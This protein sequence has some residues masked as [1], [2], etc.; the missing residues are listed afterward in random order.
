[1]LDQLPVLIFLGLLLTACLSDISTMKIP[2]WISIV[3]ATDY[4]VF[5]IILGQPLASVGLHILIGF[6]VL[7]F[8]FILFQLRILGGG[9]A[10]VLA[11]A[12]IWTG[13]EAL[14]PFAYWTVLAGGLLA[15]F[16]LFART[17]A[18]PHPYLPEFCNRLLKPGGGMPYGVAIFI[19]GVSAAPHLPIAVSALTLP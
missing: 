17:Y 6:G 7:I 12:A 15:I 3:L 16:L 14:L 19:G 5:A 1:M 2:N 10:K 8:G 13:L 18:L 9:D 11:A 4:P